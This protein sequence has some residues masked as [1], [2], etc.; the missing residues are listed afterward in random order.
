ML[1]GLWENWHLQN[2]GMQNN[3]ILMKDTLEMFIK[4]IVALGNLPGLWWVVAVGL[5]LA[6]PGPVVCWA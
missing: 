3:I 2:A 1:A 4:V 5:Q 6:R